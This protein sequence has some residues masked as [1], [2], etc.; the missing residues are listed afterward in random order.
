[1]GGLT[2]PVAAI[3]VVVRVGQQL[4][5]LAAV[6]DAAALEH[7]PA[8]VV[9]PR[10]RLDGGPVGREHLDEDGAERTLDHAAGRL[11]LALLVELLVHVLEARHGVAADLVQAALAV[12]AALFEPRTVRVVIALH[13][14]VE[15]P[16]PVLRHAHHVAGGIVLVRDPPR[17][18]ALPVDRDLLDQA[19]LAVV[20]EDG[21][22]GRLVVGVVGDRGQRLAGVEEG[23]PALPQRSV[24]P[25]VHEDHA[26]DGDARLVE[27][28]GPEQLTLGGVGEPAV[29]LHRGDRADQVQRLRGGLRRGSRQ[30]EEGSQRGGGERAPWARGEAVGGADGR[31]RRHRGPPAGGNV[32]ANAGARSVRRRGCG[33]VGS[34][35]GARVRGR[36]RTRRPPPA[37]PPSTPLGH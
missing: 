24:P 21:L 25:V 14:A 22:A 31:T 27:R 28:P 6:V 2:D 4:F 32:G 19:T 17:L 8:I 10:I 5:D 35:A 30:G 29:L 34:L 33:S 9:A 37:S 7:A 13:G 12:E 26:L 15:R 1:V 36:G 11:D 18:D 20:A 23:D 16:A 3:V